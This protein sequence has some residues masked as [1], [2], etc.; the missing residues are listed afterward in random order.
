MRPTVPELKYEMACVVSARQ[1]DRLLIGAS[2]VKSF[3]VDASIVS[4]TW[5]YN[6]HRTASLWL[7][8]TIYQTLFVP[9]IVL[10]VINRGKSKVHHEHEH[11]MEL[12]EWRNSLP[13]RGFTF[14]Q[15]HGEIEKIVSRMK[16]TKRLNNFW[17]TSPR[18]KKKKIPQEIHVAATSVALG[19]TI[20]S[21]KTRGYQCIKDTGFDLPGWINLD[22]PAQSRVFDPILGQ[23]DQHQAR[24]H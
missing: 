16:S 11:V 9:S 19:M 13:R 2:S 8:E 14:V 21:L 15:P 22:D 6:C 10:G 24:L 23:Y 4:L 18:A 20:V 3:I 12:T 7:D 5:P 1:K 17:M